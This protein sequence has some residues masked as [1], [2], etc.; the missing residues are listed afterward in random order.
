MIAAITRVRGDSARLCASLGLLW[1]GLLSGCYHSPPRVGAPYDAVIVPGCPST[2]DGGLSPCQA[3]RAAWASVVWQRGLARAFITS[4]AA[5]HSPY[6]EADALAL[7]LTTLGVPGDRIYLDREALHTDENM[8]NA[9]RIAGQLGFSHVAVAS[10]RM[11]AKGGCGMVTGHGLAC[12]PLPLEEALTQAMLTGHATE[13]ATLRSPRVAS[14]RSLADREAER[15]QQTGQRRLP[16][17]LLYPWMWLCRVFGREPNADW[18]PR[19]NTPPAPL[20][21]SD[22]YSDKRR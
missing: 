21:W 7:A 17:G 20:R 12:T 14:W 9:A 5:V 10:H 19:P 16:S 4:G 18:I 22:A 6:V 13:I 8:A 3:Q 2:A 1:L 11:Q 15:R